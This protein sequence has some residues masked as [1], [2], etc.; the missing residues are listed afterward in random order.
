MQAGAR[1]RITLTVNSQQHEVNVDPETPCCSSSMTSWVFVD[2]DSA[3]VWR[4]VALAPLF[5]GVRS[6][7]PV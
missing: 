3:A 6:C 5:G 4:N 2:R 1:Q 7:A